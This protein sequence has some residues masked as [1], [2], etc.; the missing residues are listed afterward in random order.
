MS[1]F[2]ARQ[3][4][5]LYCRFSTFLDCPTHYNMS[6]SDYVKVIMDRGYKRWKAAEE[7]KDIIENYLQPFSRVMESFRTDFM[8]V[9]EFENILVE[10]G[11][12]IDSTH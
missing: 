10:M 6:F 3:P 2:I 12:E 8:S 5:G 1:G 9:E 7:A 11:Y 4:N